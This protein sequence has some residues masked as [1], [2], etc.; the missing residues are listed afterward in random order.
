MVL[1]LVPAEVYSLK[2]SAA[3]PTINNIVS[4]DNV[5]ST[6]TAEVTALG[7]DIS[8]RTASTKTIRMSDGSYRLVQYANEVHYEDDGEWVEYDNSLSLSAS[9]N[10]QITH[11]CE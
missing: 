4:T 9:E 6:E 1:Y 7:E 5:L 10:P 2:T 8:K 11:K 3:E